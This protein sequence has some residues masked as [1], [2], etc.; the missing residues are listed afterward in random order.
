MDR[1]KQF[2]QILS[3]TLILARRQKN[4]ITHAQLATAFAPLS[5]NDAQFAEL[6]SYLGTRKIVVLDTIAESV[7]PGRV[8]QTP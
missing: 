6:E 4:R 3:D 2:A 8:S 1:E 5:F 7:E